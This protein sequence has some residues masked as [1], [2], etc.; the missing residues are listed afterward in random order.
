[1]E[2]EMEMAV[3]ALCDL[4]VIIL[5]GPAYVTWLHY[6]AHGTYSGA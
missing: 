2:M 5:T 6:T 3:W 4:H 1:M